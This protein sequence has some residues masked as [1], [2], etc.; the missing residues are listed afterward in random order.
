MTKRVVFQAEESTDWTWLLHVPVKAGDPI[1][2]ELV[3]LWH[4][5]TLVPFLKSEAA[6]EQERQR[7]DN[8][9]AL[10]G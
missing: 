1:P 9:F 5:N 4:A 3:F 10:A 7:P 8:S 2:M 6:K